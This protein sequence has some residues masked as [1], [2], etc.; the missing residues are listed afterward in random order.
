MLQV[1]STADIRDPD[2]AIR[3][4]RRALAVTFTLLTAS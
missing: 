1:S 3:R 4:Y 2:T